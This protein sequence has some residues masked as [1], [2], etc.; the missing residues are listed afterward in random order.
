M[1]EIDPLSVNA[2]TVFG[3]TL[4]MIRRYDEAS[5][6]LQKALEID[7]NFP[8]ALHFMG[9]IHLAK[10]QISDAIVFAEKTVSIYPHP[11]MIGVRG[12]YYGLAGR[13]DDAMRAL[14]ELTDFAQQSYVAPSAFVGV[15]MGLGDIVSLRKWMQASFEERDPL[16]PW[17]LTAPL[18]DNMRSDPFFQEIARKIGLPAAGMCQG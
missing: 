5:A 13:Q 16:V 6:T 9:L 11:L 18:G 4:Y 7:P 3:Q 1:I 12:G 2:L 14:H 8:T 15:Y 10:N 17:T